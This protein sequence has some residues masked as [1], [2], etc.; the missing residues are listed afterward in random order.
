MSCCPYIPG[1]A[2]RSC[3]FYRSLETFQ[4]VL[5]VF[6]HAYNKFGEVKFKHR[7]PVLH[8]SPDPQKH[9]HKFRDPPGCF[10]DFL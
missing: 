9:L 2:R 6:E 4:A 5:E 10:L 7:V 3:C 8:K 1:L